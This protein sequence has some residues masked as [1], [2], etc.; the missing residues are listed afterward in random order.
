MRRTTCSCDWPGP[1]VATGARSLR[2]AMGTYAIVGALLVAALAL[3]LWIG[4]PRPLTAHVALPA[5]GPWDSAVLDGG[6]VHVGLQRG[7]SAQIAPGRYRLTL[8]GAGGR[9]DV[10]DLDLPAGDTT[11]DN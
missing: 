5:A 1:D 2:G 10:R 8:L 7:S 11:L 9:S 6:H 3:V 4:G